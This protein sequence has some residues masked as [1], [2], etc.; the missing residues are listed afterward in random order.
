[1]NQR[2][3]CIACLAMTLTLII[4]GMVRPGFAQD[5]EALER[6]LFEEESASPWEIIADEVSYD[7]QAEVYIAR[8][9]V[10]ISQE[11]RKLTADFVRFNHKTLDATARGHVVLSA[12]EDLLIGEQMDINLRTQTGSV[13]DGTIFLAENHF[14]IQGDR[15]EKVSDAAYR[16]EGAA[17]TS[18]EGEVPDWKITGRKVDVTQEGYG[19]VRH[20]ALW[21][22]RV[23]VLY[24]PYFVFP[25]KRKRQTGLLFPEFGQSDRKGTFYLQ[26]FFWAINEQSDATFYEHYMSD[27][28][29]KVG[30]EYRYLI[31]ESSKG[32]IM[33]DFMDDRQKEDG[34]EDD[35]RFGYTGDNFLRPNSDRY[36]F[37]MKHDQDLPNGFSAR[38]DLDVVSD[39]DYL[40]EFRDGLTGFEETRDY[41]EDEFNRQLE[42]YTETV[43]TNSL[44]VSRFWKRFSLNTG[45]IWNDDVIARRDQPLVG[46]PDRAIEDTSLHQLPFAEFEAIKQPVGETPF[47]WDMSNQYVYLYSEDNSRGHRLDLHPRI[48]W[49]LKL[50]RYLSVEPSAGARQT[51]WWITEYQENVEGEADKDKQEYRFLYDLR[52]DTSTEF[53]R[54]FQVQGESLEA[55]RHTLR[56]RVIYEYIPDEDQDDLPAFF[57]VDAEGDEDADPTALDDGIN[58]IDR[59]H[60]ITYS[61]IQNL[62][63]KSEVKNTG[64]EV[65]DPTDNGNEEP[66]Y[67]YRTL[68]RLELE[69]SYD[70][71]EAREDDPE[72][73]KDP[74]RKKPFSEIRADLE[75][76]P[77]RNLTLNA[78]AEWEPYENRVITR[79]ASMAWNSL[80]GDQVRAEYRY[81]E[82]VEEDI[83]ESVY[84]SLRLKLPL[85]LTAYL[86]H[87]HDLEADERVESIAGLIYES[88]CWAVDVR[89][90]E[91]QEDQEIAFM[92]RLFGLGELGTF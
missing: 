70:I 68:A 46:G 1:M 78:E 41:F 24:T 59:R 86:S 22:R 92:V 10:E 6:E 52:L 73:R 60:L 7:D 74:D 4:S 85:R 48:Y 67:A 9:R 16:I 64:E 20:A 63:A 65:E 66:E 32:T 12:G 75:L 29:H 62:T 81:D 13:T 33:F 61:L 69:Q 43:R 91:E 26:P 50:W 72:Q 42:D 5:P 21:T 19:V 36:W 76:Y 11:N 28:G 49:P 47:Y 34:P 57:S 77:T 38:L 54:V 37:R 44:V 45:S 39:Q 14:Y 27:R 3:R 53:S 23:P 83:I 80:R 35:S 71:F 8:G 89:Y 40:T 18:C 88:Q 87:E 51:G 55:V 84:G 56:P 79:N 58:R 25:A 82:T 31:D 2:Y 17:V 90:T 15:I 30:A